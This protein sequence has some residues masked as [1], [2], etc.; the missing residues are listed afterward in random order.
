MF[1]TLV[2]R[3]GVTQFYDTTALR[4]CNEQKHSTSTRYL[5]AQRTHYISGCTYM[6]LW[7]SFSTTPNLRMLLSLRPRFSVPPVGRTQDVRII[8]GVRYILLGVRAGLSRSLADSVCSGAR[9]T[10][11]SRQGIRI[12]HTV[13]DTHNRRRKCLLNNNVLCV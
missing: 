8:Q 13:N 12:V 4:N 11:R 7:F 5:S 6:S 3:Q 1:E 2:K 10:R 9:S